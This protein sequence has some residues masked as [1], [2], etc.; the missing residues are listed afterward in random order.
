M[1]VLDKL[2][3]QTSALRHIE[4]ELIDNVGKTIK[5]PNEYVPAFECFFKRH[6][7]TVMGS[8]LYIDRLDLSK[9]I[10]LKTS[11]VKVYYVDLFNKMF[12]R[13]FKIININEIKSENGLKMFDFKLRDSVSYFLDNLYISK[14]FTGSRVSALTQIFSEYNLSSKLTE[15]KLK[16]QTEDDG[17]KGNLVLNKNLSVLDFFEKEFHRIGYSFYQDK[18]GMYIKNKENLLPGKI[19]EITSPFSQRITNQFYKN[20]IYE[21][22]TV[23]TSKEEIDKQPKQQSFYYDIEKRQMISINTNIGSLQSEIT[24]NKDNSDVQETV[25]FKAKFQ[26][27]S[28]SA[29]QKTEIIEQFLKLSTSKI[30]VNGYIENDINKVI[31]LEILGEKGNTKS[32]LA[33]D[34]VS[35]GKY[36]ILSVTDKIIADKMLQL[37]EVGRSDTGKV[38]KA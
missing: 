13:T 19:P 6:T 15:T 3:E 31:D 16:F 22:I 11:S 4:Y 14:S 10:D 2:P 26:N 17:I 37:I 29:Q 21:I 24:L 7:P 27:R 23:P 20:K 38:S 35:S 28:D 1:I 25:G 8:L 33:G 9:Q 34:E 12:F 18:S 5:L 30:V 32:H 36:I